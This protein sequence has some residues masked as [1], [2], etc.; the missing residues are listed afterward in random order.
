MTKEPGYLNPG[1]MT[2]TC[3]HCGETRT[4]E[5]PVKQMP[6]SLFNGDLDK[7]GPE[8]GEFAETFDPL[9]IIRQP[10]AGTIDR[11]G[12]SVVLSVEAAGGEPPYA[13]QWHMAYNTNWVPFWQDA[14]N[15]TDSTLE[16]KNG[17]SNY[18]CTVYDSKGDHVNSDLVLIG[19]NLYIAR[20]PENTSCSE[21]DPIVL[22]CGAAGGLPYG[23]ETDY[24]Y[25]YQWFDSDGNYVGYGPKYTAEKMGKYY[26]LVTDNAMNTVQSVSAIAYEA[27]PF[28][29]KTDA[30]VVELQ[31]GQEYELRAEAYGGIGPYTGVWL[32][33]GVEIPTQQIKE[34]EFTAP[35]VGDGSKEVVYTFLATDAMDDDCSV[36]VSVRKYYEPL[37]IVSQNLETV[38]KNAELGAEW[39][40]EITPGTVPY[41][42]TLLR[43]GET[44]ESKQSYG[45]HE[46]FTIREGGWYADGRKA[47][48][49]YT[50]VTDESLR[51]ADFTGSLN[52]SKV[53]MNSPDNFLKVT[54]EGGTPPYQYRWEMVSRDTESL[55]SLNLPINSDEN[56]DFGSDSL[57]VFHPCTV[58]KCTVTDDAGAKAVAYPMNVTYNGLLITKQP[59]DVIFDVYDYK[60]LYSATFICEAVGP[61]GHPLTYQWEQKTVT[62]WVTFNKSYKTSISLKE[63]RNDH[64]TYR[65]GLAFR[66]IVKDTVTGDTLTSREAR[67]VR[68]PLEVEACQVGT[69][70]TIDLTIKGGYGVYSI[71]CTRVTEE[72]FGYEWREPYDV[73]P[74]LNYIEGDAVFY[75]K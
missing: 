66:C 74:H 12:G 10:A 41:T 58:W 50:E 65:L 59:E 24:P 21:M 29:A 71:S 48:I 9:R 31:D 13:Y 8:P 69:G 6:I 4:E 3:A 43:E 19:W 35:I 37:T 45:T 70:K 27:D 28:E 47:D 64:T 2:Y 30:P 1:E 7:D 68:P 26:C 44:G 52:I 61:E 40:V 60:T 17:S 63:S 54:A 16:A 32:R 36:A 15:G 49:D 33:D 34:G 72:A 18:Y 56:P 5:I 51:I 67:V 39:Y 46:A 73:I 22:T 57:Q 42:Y 75:V 11:D 23:E 53:N 55:K 14:E 38:I 25:V 20:Q 62:G